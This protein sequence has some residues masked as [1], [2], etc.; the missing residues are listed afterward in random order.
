MIIYNNA[1]DQYQLLPSSSTSYIYSASLWNYE[2]NRN[3]HNQIVSCVLLEQQIFIHNQT[4]FPPL[5]VIYK[6]VLRGKYYFTRSFSAYSS[7]EINCEQ[8]DSN[9]PP[10]HTL[11]W[12][13]NDQNQTLF[14]RTKQGRFQITNATWRN[15]GKYCS[16]QRRYI[17]FHLSGIYICLGEND[18]NNHQPVHQLFRLNIWFDEHQFQ[19]NKHLALSS[20]TFSRKNMSLKLIVIIL[21]FLFACFLCL[22]SLYCF[23]LQM[24]SSIA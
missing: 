5:N 9:P 19:S 8:F 21:I 10:V 18:L 2:L 4:L 22:L 11:V 3:D 14:N 17:S 1:P 12:M 20:L 16:I 23:C 24:K 15:R 13:L 7:I 6:A